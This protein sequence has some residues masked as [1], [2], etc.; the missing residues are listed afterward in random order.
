MRAIVLV[1]GFGTRLRPLTLTT[2]KQMLPVLHRP[3]IERVVGHLARHG[4]SEVV[5]SL[6]YRPDAF[7]EAYPDDMCAGVKLFYAVEPEPLD[8]A[9]AIRFAATE[10]GMASTF[11]VINGDVLTDLDISALVDYHRDR[12]GDATIHLTPVEDPSRFGVVPID[13]RGRVQAFV[14]KPPVGEAP[15]NWINAGAYVCEPA[16]IER[17]PNRASSIEREVF[18]RMVN[19]GVLYA[20]QADGYWLDAGTPVTYLAAQMD[21]L[22]RRRRDLDP[23]PAVHAEATVDPGAQV[24]RSVVGAGATVDPGAEI[25]DSLLLPG[26]RVASGA[27]VLG[28]VL[29]RYSVVEQRAELSELTVVGDEQ[30]VESGRCLVGER[31]PDPE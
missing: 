20:Y 14:E 3:M 2:P 4:V 26:A 19:D 18:P 24:I 1:G 9:G 29:G 21:L 23:E 31:L 30:V 13:E 25:R 15:T 28:S 10:A 11:L 16:V 6:G 8:T 27:R 17:I 5:L 7:L 22:D 12:G